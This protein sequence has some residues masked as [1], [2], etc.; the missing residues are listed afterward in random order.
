MTLIV[1][2]MGHFTPVLAYN[3]LCIASKIDSKDFCDILH[4]Q[5]APSLKQS[6]SSRDFVKTLIS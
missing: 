1:A 2:K 5:S 6:Q 3:F 4:N